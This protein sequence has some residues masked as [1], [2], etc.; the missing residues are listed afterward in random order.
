MQLKQMQDEAND[1]I[2][3]QIQKKLE[4]RAGQYS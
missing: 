2:F 3:T 1:E 4:K